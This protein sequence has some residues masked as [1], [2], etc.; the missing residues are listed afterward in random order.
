MLRDYGHA[1]MIAGLPNRSAGRLSFG[2]LLY[3]VPKFFDGGELITYVFQFEK[4]T[5]ASDESFVAD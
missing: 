1:A 2:R 4:K 3:F 5:D